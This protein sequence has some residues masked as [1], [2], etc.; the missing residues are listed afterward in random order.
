METI[1][2]K[3][4]HCTLIECDPDIKTKDWYAWNNLMPPGPFTFHV[5]GLVEVPNPGVVA[6]LIYKEPQGINPDILL[7]DLVLI[8]RPGVWPRVLTWVE[9]RYDKVGVDLKYTNVNIFCGDQMVADMKVD[10]IH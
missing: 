8:Q 1:Q 10:D 9:A 5:K 4:G 2:T 3:E 7:L 6:Q